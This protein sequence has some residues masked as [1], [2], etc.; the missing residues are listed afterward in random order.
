MQNVNVE[1]IAE[2]KNFICLVHNTPELLDLFRQQKSDFTRDRKLPF[3]KLVLLILKLCKRTLSVELEQ[4]F[5][6]Q[7]LEES[8]SV[9]AF[10]QQRSK[11]IPDFFRALNAV[12][13]Q[14]YYHYCVGSV[15]RWKNYRV[16]AGDGSS[17][18]LISNDALEKFF[19]GQRNRFGSFSLGKAF[20]WYDVLNGL[21]IFS[22]LGPYRYSELDMAYDATNHLK[23]DMLMIYDRNFSNYKMI[24]LHQW[25]E[26]PVKFIIRGKD[27]QII[28]RDFMQS[29]LASQ[30]IW[31][32]PGQNAIKGLKK[33]G[34]IIT[35]KTLIRVRLVRVDLADKTEVLMTNL[36]EEDGH[37]IEEFKSL[38]NM[39]WGIETQIGLQ[40]N[41]LQ[42]ESFSGLTHTAV[43]QDFY[44]TVLISNL[45]ALLIKDAQTELNRIR[46]RKYP[47]KVNNNK[48]F[49]KL[50]L[51]LI[52]L[53]LEN[54]PT[55]IIS[56]LQQYFLKDPL[57]KR[58]GRKF[59]RKVKNPRTKS[60][61]RTFSNYKP[62][63]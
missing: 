57:P 17:V 22:R 21:V 18:S 62:A 61:H 58:D 11:L 42:L 45:H 44:A 40:K 6:D 41:I 31:M 59:P 24:A 48:A 35:S 14:S 37:T 60:K 7:K 28:I 49:G 43:Q 8:C 29:G 19:G 25:Q 15:K 1:I 16:I 47:L 20:Y 53:F 33:S 30:E 27:S 50:K 2:L 23:E 63:F 56:K 55:E 51:V 9:S 54:D 5:T 32:K 10:S 52:S 12:L 13:Y 36:W 4:F 3:D 26:T 46:H 38:Y 34:Y 39:R